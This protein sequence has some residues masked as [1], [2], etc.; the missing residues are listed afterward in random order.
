MTRIGQ[1]ASKPGPK[2]RIRGRNLNGEARPNVRLF[3][4][5]SRHK[6]AWIQEANEP[7]ELQAGKSATIVEKIEW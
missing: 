4:G 1:P 3:Q 5:I 2:I 6:V 7:A